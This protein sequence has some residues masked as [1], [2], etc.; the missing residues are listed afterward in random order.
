MGKSNP[1]ITCFKSHATSSASLMIPKNSVASII[2]KLKKFGTT[3]T[4]PRAK[5][6][7]PT[8]LSNQGR[9]AL[10]R[11]V[12]KNLMF[13]LAEVQRSCVEMGETSQRT[14]ITATLHQSVLYGRVA[15]RKPLLSERRMKAKLSLC[16]CLKN[17]SYVTKCDGGVWGRT[18]MHRVVG[19]KKGIYQGQAEIRVKHRQG[20]E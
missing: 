11:E 18:Q 1:Q 6:S 12:T 16:K 7:S 10:V 4:L 17:T 15:R 2:L 9:R 20:S 19:V 3:R 8:K 13:T 14:T 5:M